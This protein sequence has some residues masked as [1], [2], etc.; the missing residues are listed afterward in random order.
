[1]PLTRTRQTETIYIKNDNHD[2]TIDRIM[3]LISMII[4]QPSNFG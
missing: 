1:M 4:S 2:D 3:S